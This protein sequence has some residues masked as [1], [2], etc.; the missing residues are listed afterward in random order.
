MAQRREG[1]A[2]GLRGGHVEPPFR[3]RRRPREHVQRRVL[4]AAPYGSGR[5]RCRTRRRRREEAPRP[6]EHAELPSPRNLVAVEVAVEPG[7]E[8]PGLVHALRKGVVLVAAGVLH[9]LRLGRA[10]LGEA[11]VRLDVDARRHVIGQAHVVVGAGRVPAV[12]VAHE[13]RVL[14]RLQH[15]GVVVGV[16]VQLAGERGQRLVEAV[17]AR[18]GVRVLVRV[19]LFVR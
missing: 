6:V 10:L 5:G 11:R 12:V 8:R 9:D 19:G 7:L 15:R 3:C 4:R 13:R 2:L 1:R 17:Q 18:Y 16:Q 14:E